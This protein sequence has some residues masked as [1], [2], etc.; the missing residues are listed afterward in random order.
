LLPRAPLSV[1][2]ARKAQKSCVFLQNRCDLGTKIS[3][4]YTD[5]ARAVVCFHRITGFA[6]KKVRDPFSGILPRKHSP[7]SQGY[8]AFREAKYLDQFSKQRVLGLGGSQSRP[9]RLDDRT[10]RGV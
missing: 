9:G 2:N 8:V 5:F 10:R 3:S 1:A 4:F 6:R 7:A